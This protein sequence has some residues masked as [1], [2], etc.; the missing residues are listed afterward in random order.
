MATGTWAGLNIKIDDSSGN[1]QDISQY[2]TAISGVNVTAPTV[3]VTPAGVSYLKKLF[4]GLLS[5]DTVTLDMIYDDT[6]ST[7]PKALFND[8]GCVATSGGTR[9]LKVTYFGTNYT[10]VE[11][12]IASFKRQPVKG[13][14]TMC[15]ASLDP[16][17]TITEN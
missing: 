11:V 9:T 10:S 12:I 3:D 15:Q 2:V 4:G 16:T 1:P 7:G 13:T 5:M 6:A 17:G 8:T 14:P